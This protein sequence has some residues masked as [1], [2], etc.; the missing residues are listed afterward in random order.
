M[1]LVFLDFQAHSPTNPLKKVLSTLENSS[2]YSAKIN[3][4]DLA[5]NYL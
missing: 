5:P 1:L 2:L 4:N 3:V